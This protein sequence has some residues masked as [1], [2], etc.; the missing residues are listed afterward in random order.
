MGMGATEPSIRGDRLVY[1][2]VTREERD[3]W[4][5]PGPESDVTGGPE[6]VI[7]GNPMFDDLGESVS[8]DNQR[9][10]FE[11]DRSGTSEIWVANA[12]GSDPIQLTRF[13]GPDCNFPAW[14][15]DGQR[16]TF[17]S[18]PAGQKGV[19]I[20]DAEGGEPKRLTQGGSASW[21]HDGRWIY[22]GSDRSG[23]P[24][25][26]KMP[27]EGGEASQITQNGGQ[28][29]LE[30][31]DGEH[32]YYWKVGSK[33]ARG[34]IWR[35]PVEGGEEVAVLRENLHEWNWDLQQNRIYWVPD[36]S[37]NAYSIHFLDLEAEKRTELIRQEQLFSVNSLSAAPNGKWV[38]YSARDVTGVS[39][40]I[41]LVENFR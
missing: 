24:Q 26:W 17:H 33:R 9:I 23:D 37:G 29:P 39:R 16:I 41:M 32:L 8:S 38:Y 31:T 14:S 3:I 22:F 1:V 6:R 25:V 36:E 40:D 7:R 10:A 12:D 2:H 5:I 13:G 30:S 20:V 28:R 35:V 4:R 19:Y 21:S 11:S 15:P 34:W 18:N 27:A